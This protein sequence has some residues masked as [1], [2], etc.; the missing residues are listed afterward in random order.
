MATRACGRRCAEDGFT[1]IEL[2]VVVLI[3]G[4]L[5]AIALP[6]FLGARSRAQNSAAKAS[7]RTAL[8]AGRVLFSTDQDGYLNVTAL[9]LTEVETSVLWLPAA[10]GSDT[11]TA[12]SWDNAGGVLTLAAYSKAGSCFFLEDDP[13]NDTQY[14]VLPTTVSADCRANNSGAAAFGPSW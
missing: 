8:A 1:L 2:M 4:I 10:S 12:V 11:P 7:V 14:A 5:V 13:P 9:R 6:T 3:L